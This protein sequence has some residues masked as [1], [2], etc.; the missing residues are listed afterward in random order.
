VLGVQMVLFALFT[1]QLAIRSGWLPPDPKFDALMSKISLEAGLIFSIIL[2]ILGVVLTLQAVGAWSEAA[3]AALDPRVTMRKV[4]PAVTALTLS[5]EILLASF[6]IE[7]IR[8][9]RPGELKRPTLTFSD[10]QDRAS[11]INAAA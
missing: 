2:F 7:V 4:V 9:R 1:K 8:V 3:F 10:P 6:F 11:A 5:G